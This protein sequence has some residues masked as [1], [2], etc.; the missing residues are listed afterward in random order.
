MRNSIVFASFLLCSLLFSI[1]YCA[2]AQ[3]QG[4]QQNQQQQQQQQTAVVAAI[5]K[6]LLRNAERLAEREKMARMEAIEQELSKVQ[7]QSAYFTRSRG[8][9]SAE[10]EGSSRD[11]LN[12]ANRHNWA[13]AVKAMTDEDVADEQVVG[14]LSSI[15]PLF[16]E[17][18]PLIFSLF[19]G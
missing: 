10:K 11:G 1:S 6:L 18:L 4:V 19:S 14:F 2:P 7:A 16:T 8:W 3:L 12:P 17:F 15:I 9:E 5:E 13:E